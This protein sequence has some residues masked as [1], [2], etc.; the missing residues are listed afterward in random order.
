MSPPLATPLYAQKKL[1]VVLGRTIDAL[2]YLH[3]ADMLCNAQNPLH[4][5]PRNFPV[6]GKVANLSRTCCQQVVVMEFGNR[7]D[8]S[9]TTDLTPEQ[10]LTGM[11]RA[12]RLG[13][14]CGLV[15]G[16]SPTCYG[17]ATGKLM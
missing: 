11:L 9:D 13:L 17:L 2:H 12:C 8:T 15:T 4:A 5:F 16:K 10:L 7:H 3:N 1:S 6:D 14:C